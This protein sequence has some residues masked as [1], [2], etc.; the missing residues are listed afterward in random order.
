MML[1]VSV[2]AIRGNTERKRGLHLS[3]FCRNATEASRR[4]I[5]CSGLGLLR[6]ELFP[7]EV[8]LLALQVICRM[9]WL[10]I[11][12]LLCHDMPRD[13]RGISAACRP[14][15][16]CLT[17]MPRF[18]YIKLEEGIAANVWVG[19]FLQVV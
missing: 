5:L 2:S 17:G 1:S 3:C 9:K 6:E 18:F 10:L 4:F 13:L 19:M 16:G 15:F 7:L 12:A 8:E 14:Q 11:G